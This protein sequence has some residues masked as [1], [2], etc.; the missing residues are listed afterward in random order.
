MAVTAKLK[1]P[2]ANDASVMSTRWWKNSKTK[3]NQKK[4][5]KTDSRVQWFL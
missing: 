2:K 3:L 4:L 5:N 1:I